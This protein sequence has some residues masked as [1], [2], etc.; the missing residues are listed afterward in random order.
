MLEEMPR[1]L[2]GRM[3]PH[4]YKQYLHRHYIN[5]AC[6]PRMNCSIPCRHCS[7]LD[8]THWMMLSVTQLAALSEEQ[9][10]E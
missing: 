3:F 8:S 9:R 5:P 2:S 4:L 6:L 7:A 1:M 10:N